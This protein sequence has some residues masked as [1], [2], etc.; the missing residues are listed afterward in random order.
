MNNNNRFIDD[1]GLSESTSLTHLLSDDDSSDTLDINIIKH[2]PYYSE[3]DFH[4]LQFMKGNFSILSLN[5]Q[6]INAKFDELQLFMDRINRIEEVSV[7]CLQETWTSD[8]DDIS[9]F[10]L[11]HYK[12]LHRG[13]QC[14]KHSGLFI[15][16]HDKFYV[17]PLDLPFTCTKWEGYCIKISQTEPFIKH[18]IIANIY[19][20]PY[21]GSEDF[22]VFL[23]E[24]NDF[25]NLLQNYG[26]SLHIC[27]DFNI[28]LLKIHSKPHYNI[29]F[30]NML[31]SGFYP[32]ITLPTQICDTSSTIIDNI[33]SNEIDC[34]DNSGI[35][36]NHIS[37]HQAIFTITSTKCSIEMQDQYVT[38]QTN[39]DASLNNFVTELRNMNIT[40]SLNNNVNANP[41][42]NY[43][44]FIK[45]LQEAKN[46]H[47]PVRKIKFNK[48][49]HKK[50]KWITRGILKSIPSEQ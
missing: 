18:H 14:C 28:N 29:F 25:V 44:K 40:D 33:Y 5:C 39:D 21:E 13:K 34:N 23:K 27:G 31:S 32:K 8:K 17:E 19:K 38:I 16:V 48:Y 46:K 26:H 47:L 1:I 43:D 12:L 10:Q 20:P 36:I 35:L 45:L 15:Y 42:Q 41:S 6:S 4:N 3:S 7:L 37:D 24:F 9:L 2:S 50:N 30:E 49:K 11:S 22:D